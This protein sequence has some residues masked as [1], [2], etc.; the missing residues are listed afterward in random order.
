MRH[1]P[2]CISTTER[3]AR[4]PGHEAQREARANSIEPW[5]PMGAGP[6]H[7]KLRFCVIWTSWRNSGDEGG[8]EEAAARGLQP[9]AWPL[10][11]PW[12][13]EEEKGSSKRMPTMPC[14][15]KCEDNSSATT[16]W[17]DVTHVKDSFLQVWGAA[18][19]CVAPECLGKLYRRSPSPDPQAQNQPWVCA[20]DLRIGP[21]RPR[22]Q[23]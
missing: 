17:M 23:E 5:A 2:A 22:F 16:S 20:L 8:G 12:S 6:W 4:R 13:A 11:D 10:S 9:Q 15:A 14:A 19:H 3:P 1:S 7:R 21:S 18:S